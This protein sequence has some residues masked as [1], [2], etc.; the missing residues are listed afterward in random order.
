LAGSDIVNRLFPIVGQQQIH[1]MLHTAAQNNRYANAYLF[2]GP[3]GTGKEAMA[4]EFAALMNCQATDGKPCGQCIGCKQ[5]RQLQHPNVHLLFALPGGDSGDKNDP[6]KGLSEAIVEEIHHSIIEKSRQP[7]NRIQIT[8]AQNIKISSVRSMQKSIHLGQAEAGRNVVLIFEAE[9]MNT[10]AFNSILKVVEEPPE[11][12]SFIFC[13]SAGHLIPATIRSRCQSVLFR[14]LTIEEI[15]D[16]LREQTELADDESLERIARMADGDFGA[17]LALV[18]S[19]LDATEEAV[20]DFVRAVMKGEGLSIKRQADLLE[21]KYK[22]SPED[23]RRFLA[24]IQLWF[25]D[26]HIWSE[27]DNQTQLIF[28]QMPDKIQGFV[29]YYPET[30]YATVHA[31]LENAIDFIERN[32]YIRLALFSLQ[33]Q[34]HLATRGKLKG[35]SYGYSHRYHTNSIR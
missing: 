22:E 8:N 18:G 28:R 3:P 10:A 7:Y 14:T 1:D 25:R 17:A 32:V 13:T 23:F 21:N 9:R 26:A 15:K 30:D 6:L 19:N 12:T 2:E 27:T 11:E 4:M 16:G 33:V 35:K 31:L 24:L 34:L 5:I 29:D 20:L